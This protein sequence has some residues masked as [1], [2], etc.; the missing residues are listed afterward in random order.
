M[1]RQIPESEGPTQHLALIQSEF[2][3][4]FGYFIIFVNRKT[5]KQIFSLPVSSGYY[6]KSV[7]GYIQDWCAK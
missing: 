5:K 2:C 4:I 6:E 1:F 7:E 3:G